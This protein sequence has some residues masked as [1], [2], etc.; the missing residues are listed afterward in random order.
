MAREL[1]DSPVVRSS[2]FI[3]TEQA[4]IF[5]VIRF[6]LPLVGSIKGPANSSHISWYKNQKGYYM[7]TVVLFPIR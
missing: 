7:P 5:H 6:T 4:V 2:I 3:E 1:W